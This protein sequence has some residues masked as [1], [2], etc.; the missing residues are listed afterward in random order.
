MPA[1]LTI[2]EVADEL[3]VSRWTVYRLIR[4]RELLPTRVRG[5]VPSAVRSSTATWIGRRRKI[6]RPSDNRPAA[7]S[8]R[9]GIAHTEVPLL[10][11]GAKQ[12]R[13]GACWLVEQ[14]VVEQTPALEQCRLLYAALAVLEAELAELK[15]TLKESGRE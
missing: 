11:E 13:R 3:H 15:A 12:A 1:L 5:V 9:L 7:P 6:A 14:S 8:R 4:D 2:P 10:T